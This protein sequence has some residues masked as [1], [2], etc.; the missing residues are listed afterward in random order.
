MQYNDFGVDFKYLMVNEKD[1]KFGITVNTVGFQPVQPDTNYPSPDH[2]KSYY[3]KPSR[4]R[5]LSEYQLIYITKGKGVFSS[6]T[7]KKGVSLFYSPGSGIPTVRMLV[8]VGMNIT[9]VSKD[10]LLIPL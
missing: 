1:R 8:Q 5:V 7:T 9:L 4:G 6:E 3:F 10:L 2:P